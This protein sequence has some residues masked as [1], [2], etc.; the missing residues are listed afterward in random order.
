VGSIHKLIDEYGKL[1]AIEHVPVRRPHRPV[2]AASATMLDEM[3][4]E[5]S[6]FIYSG[7]CHAALPH[8]KLDDA[9][10]WQIETGYITLVV[11]PGTTLRPDGSH[12]SVGIPF[13]PVSRLIL[14]Y[15]QTRALE[16]GSRHVELG[17]TMQGF[18][19]RL[20]LSQGG[21]T[22]RIVRDQIERI[23]HCKLTFHLNQNGVRGI[24]NQSIVESAIF[25]GDE[26]DRRDK[27][28]ANLFTDT[29]KLSEGFF[30]QLRRHAVRLDE[31]AIRKI[32]NSSRVLDLYCF[33]AFR[34]H[35]LTAPTPISW[36][37]LRP[38]FG[39]GLKALHHFKAQFLEDLTMALSVYSEARVDVDAKGVLLHPSPPPVVTRR[40][41]LVK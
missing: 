31:A 13:G 36:A 11:E 5:V 33:L 24:A 8:R 22:N 38:Q 18:L 26:G 32:H 19:G 37:A 25:F 9:V 21:K 29:L 35:H 40:P 16:T 39:V 1:L 10:K 17:K 7:W 4:G 30:D 14:I 3:A 20:G 28:Q 15:L 27:R 2:E 6:N 12:Q 41:R 23:S 34:L